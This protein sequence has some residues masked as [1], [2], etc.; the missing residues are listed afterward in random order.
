MIMPL[1]LRGMTMN[2]IKC[3]KCGDTGAT[4]ESGY[5]DCAAPGCTAAAERAEMESFIDTKRHML[6]ESVYEL[7]WL[8]HQR[9]T[10]L[11]QKACDEYIAAQSIVVKL[12]LDRNT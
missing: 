4:S 7:A 1:T 12:P 2:H 8:V 11:A 9:A 5:L 6:R 3:E 10:A